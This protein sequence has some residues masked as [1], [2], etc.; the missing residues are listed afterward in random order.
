[1][2]RQPRRDRAVVEQNGE[3]GTRSARQQH[4]DGNGRHPIVLADRAHQ[5]R[6]DDIARQPIDLDISVLA[7]IDSGRYGD[8]VWRRDAAG[9]AVRGRVESV[10]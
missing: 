10:G 3:A 4:V 2:I 8:E 7:D 9:I 5:T 6:T 1:M